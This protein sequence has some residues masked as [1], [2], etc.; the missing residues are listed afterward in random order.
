[1]CPVHEDGTPR[2]QTDI[3]SAPKGVSV[4]TPVLLRFSFLPLLPPL[5]SSHQCLPALS[6]TVSLDAILAQCPVGAGNAE[7]SGKKE[8]SSR[9]LGLF[10]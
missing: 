4:R 8:E 2:G 5:S 3:S 10:R 9:E 1:M 6:I 7:M